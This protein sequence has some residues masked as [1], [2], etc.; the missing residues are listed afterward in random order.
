MKKRLSACVQRLG[1]D[2]APNEW[3]GK[4]RQQNR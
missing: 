3:T 1:N 2:M 4:I